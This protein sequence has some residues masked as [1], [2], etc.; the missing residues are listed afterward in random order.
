[1]E[2][3][4]LNLAFSQKPPALDFVFGGLL[5]GTV[6]NI[7]APGSTGKSLLA[8]E[9]AM[10]IACPEIDDE[11]LQVDTL[12]RGDVTVINAEDPPEILRS[13]L[14]AIKNCL[15]DDFVDEIRSR[16]N[17]YSLLGKQPDITKADLQNRIIEKCSGNR[18]IIF[19]TFTR[20][21]TANENDN[22][23]MSQVVG[24][25]ERIAKET[26]AAVLF[27]HHASK[28][29]ALNGQHAEQQASRGASAIT[30]NCRWQG[31]LQGMSSEDAVG[32]GVQEPDRKQFVRFGANKE[33]Y[34]RAT[35]EKWLMRG[36]GG[37]LLASA[38]K[39]KP[40]FAVVNGKD[41]K[42]EWR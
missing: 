3:I 33:N 16:L 13:R 22:G 42:G 23:Q 17:I 14:F 4:D 12:T 21:H 1:M 24:C 7:T 35:P 27:L 25:Y 2:Q 15:H 31:Y 6:G 5:A 34:G 39:A 19:D 20:F 8:L 36:D 18:L 38:M 41:K 40:K 37:V 9:L 11:L 28:G 10:T 32:H 26:G 29:A 30:D